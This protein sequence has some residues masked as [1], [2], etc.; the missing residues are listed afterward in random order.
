MANIHYFWSEEIPEGL[1]PEDPSDPQEFLAVLTSRARRSG[2]DRGW[3]RLL[4]ESEN[5][6]LVL[7]SPPAGQG[8][9]ALPPDAGP[10]TGKA[11]L[12]PASPVESDPLPIRKVLKV[13]GRKVGYFRLSAFRQSAVEPLKQTFRHFRAQG[14][15]DLVVDLRT[16]PGGSL[17]P[18]EALAN[19]LL[20]GAGRRIIFE[21]RYNQRMRGKNKT[22]RFSPE[23]NALHPDRL[24][25]LTNSG[26]ASASELLISALEP[27]FQRK[28]A[29]VGTRT[30][31]KPLGTE[32]FPIHP[33]G[34][35][36]HLVNFEVRNADG[37]GRYFDGLPYPGFKGVTIRATDE[38]ASP[39]GDQEAGSLEA[40][41]DWIRTGTDPGRPIGRVEERPFQGREP[42]L[43]E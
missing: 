4:T 9:P 29:M 42:R 13:A 31:G 22:W 30:A 40:A 10:G 36:L 38:V 21:Q 20:P 5:R 2:K 23:P 11:R 1:S 7:G 28:L 17:G 25:F 32:A 14:V 15:T 16:N 12:S 34:W 33:C 24:A 19:L 37:K 35:V 41:L 3:T 18:V 43:G 6:S 8:I 26:T 27:Y 39:L